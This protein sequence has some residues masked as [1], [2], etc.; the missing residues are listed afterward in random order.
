MAGLQDADGFDH[1]A[2]LLVGHADH[3]ALG[4]GRVAQQGVFHLGAAHVVAGGDDH[5]VVAR[6]VEEV[7]VGVLRERIARVVPAVLHILGLARVV[8]VLAARGAD[9]RELA[10]GAARHFTAVVVHHLGGVA[11]H[12]LA[13][14]AC[15]AFAARRRDED[16][17]H[18]RGADTVRHVEAGRVFPQLARRVR[19]ALARA[20]A[21]AQ[22]GQADLLGEG[23][24]LPIEGGGG[25]ADGHARVAHQAHHGFGRVGLVGEVHAGPRPHRKHQQATEAEGERQRRRARHDVARCGAQHVA[26]PGLAACEH[27][28]VRVHGGLGCAGGSGGEGHQRDVVGRRGAGRR[29]AGLALRA[30]Q[31]VGRIRRCVE[32]HDGGEHGVL[33]LRGLQLGQQAAVAQCQRGLGAVDDVAQLARAQQ[34]HGRHRHQPGVDSTQPGQRHL[35]RVAAAQQHTVAGHEAVVQRQHLGNARGLGAGVAVGVR[36]VWAAQQGAVDVA[37]TFGLVEQRLHQVG[38]V[39]DLQLRQVVAQRGPGLGCRHAVVHEM[40]G[41]GGGGFHAITPAKRPYR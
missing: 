19:Q 15:A 14:C 2:A 18:L 4:H 6:L 16:V 31:Q 10:H 24:H 22:L 33:R 36:A 9:H 12:H 11:G 32:G 38:L 41:L 26:W 40:V 17:E 1:H 29:G 5:V 3:A 35:H 13:H 21:G 28:A 8:E 25:V 34:R 23:C 30:L 27:V 20:H 7:P 39:G 37:R